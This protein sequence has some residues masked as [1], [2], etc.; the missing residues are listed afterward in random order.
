MVKEWDRVTGGFRIE[1]KMWTK[2][3][4]PIKKGKEKKTLPNSYTP[5]KIINISHILLGESNPNWKRLNNS[6]H[7]L[8]VAN[9]IERT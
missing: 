4:L 7:D 2:K 8:E 6:C 3:N 5:I 9:S 1:Y